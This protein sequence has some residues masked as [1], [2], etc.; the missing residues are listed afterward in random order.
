MLQKKHL[1]KFTLLMLY[2]GLFPLSRK[3]LRLFSTNVKCTPFLRAT[4]PLCKIFEPKQPRPQTESQ[5]RIITKEWCN[6]DLIKKINLLMKKNNIKN[7]A[8]LSQKTNIPY[9]TLK[10]IFDGDVNDIRLSTS[11]KICN[12]FNITLDELLDDNVDFNYHRFDISGL[13][14][15]D[16]KSTEKYI[17]FLKFTKKNY[18][19]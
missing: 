8:Q 14:N 16:I 3:I 5:L 12:F 13:D 18:D 11:K 17:D 9:T 6:M 2:N 7:I 19:K 4:T 1:L 10:S 15:E